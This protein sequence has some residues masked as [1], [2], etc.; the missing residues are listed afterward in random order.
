MTSTPYDTASFYLPSVDYFPLKGL[1]IKITHAA[2]C[3]ASERNSAEHQVAVL[4]T[5]ART[6]SGFIFVL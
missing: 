3:N 4:F 1:K 5:P 6:A 2:G